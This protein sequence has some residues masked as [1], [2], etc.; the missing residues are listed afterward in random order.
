MSSSDKSDP[1]GLRFSG[2]NRTTPTEPWPLRPQ[3]KSDDLPS[4]AQRIAP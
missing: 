2:Q 1:L 3:L 4:I